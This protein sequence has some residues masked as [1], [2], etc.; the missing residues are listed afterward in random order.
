MFGLLCDNTAQDRVKGYSHLIIFCPISLS[1]NL[2]RSATLVLPANFLYFTPYLL[3]RTELQD[4]ATV[5]SKGFV[6]QFFWHSSPGG[7]VVHIGK[8]TPSTISL[9]GKLYHQNKSSTSLLFA[10]HHCCR[11]ESGTFQPA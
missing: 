3:V 6:E 4:E 7:D 2:V 11:V 8:S 10:C 1:R 5:H 9:K